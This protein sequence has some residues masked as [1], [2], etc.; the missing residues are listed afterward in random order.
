MKSNLIFDISPLVISG[1]DGYLARH[2]WSER[3][4]KARRMRNYKKHSATWAFI[5]NRFVCGVDPFDSFRRAHLI[6]RGA[7]NYPLRYEYFSSNDALMIAYDNAI[8]DLETFLE[9][10]KIGKN[11]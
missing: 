4:R 9:S 11:K 1:I 3:K 2:P 10:I 6:I 7:E 8:N 5:K